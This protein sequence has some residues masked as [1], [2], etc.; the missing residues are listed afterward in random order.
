MHRFVIE[1]DLPGVGDL[2]LDALRLASFGSN[3][4]IS[5]MGTG[6]QWIRTNVTENRMYCEYL[7]TSEQIVREH[8]ARAGLP[9]N[10]VSRVRQVID[11]LTA[12]AAGS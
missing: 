6:I 11:P 1:R 7:A 8:A 4:A 3:K 12:T 9:A 5:D 2:S 10:R